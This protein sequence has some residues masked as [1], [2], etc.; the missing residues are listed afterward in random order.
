MLHVP[1]RGGAPATQAVLA[2][3][4]NLNFMEVAF[5]RLLIGTG[6][7]LA[8]VTTT[9]VRSPLFPDIPTLRV[10]GIE[11]FESATYRAMMAPAGTPQPVLDHVADIVL[12]Y[13]RR[14]ETRATVSNAGFLPIVGDAAAFTAH[15]DADTAR[16]GEVIR[17]RIIR[18]S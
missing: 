2:R 8:V 7:I 13:G 4:V 10:A 14:E 5:V 6:H 17:C 1:Y 11:G 15:K 12:R 18:L 3:E 16:W 9:P